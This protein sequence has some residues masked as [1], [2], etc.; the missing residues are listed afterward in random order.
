MSLSVLA[1]N[2]HC[3]GEQVKSQV[4]FT[5]RSVP[6]GVLA[7]P[8]TGF[9]EVFFHCDGLWDAF[10]QLERA[11]GRVPAKQIR[12]TREGGRT[13][14]TRPPAAAGACPTARSR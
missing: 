11:R 14:R 4:I 12:E 6:L 10:T 1:R 13:E 2:F 3:S 8:C 5:V 9:P 7:F